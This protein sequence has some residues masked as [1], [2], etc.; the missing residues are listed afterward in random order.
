MKPIEEYFE[1]YPLLHGFK[2]SW[3]RKIMPIMSGFGQEASLKKRVK[4]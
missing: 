3:H 1:P 4:L 2:K